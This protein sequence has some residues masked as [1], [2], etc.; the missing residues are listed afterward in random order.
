MGTNL[1]THQDIMPQV[2][3]LDLSHLAEICEL[4]PRCYPS[5]WSADLIRGEFLNEV[6]Y[7]L[8]LT[9][10]WNVV[11]YSFSHFLKPELHLLNLAVAPEYRCRGYGKYLLCNLLL[12]AAREGVTKVLL[13]VRSSNYIARKL[14]S[15]LNFRTVGVRRNYYQDNNEDALLLE[16]QITPN[17]TLSHIV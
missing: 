12:R 8:G 5:P 3:L 16:L 7:R 13:E 15:S 2:T 14:Y 9:M 17:R 11:G 4:E 10:D 1:A 6:S